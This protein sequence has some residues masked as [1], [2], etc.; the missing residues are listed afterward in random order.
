MIDKIINQMCD[1]CCDRGDFDYTKEE[2]YYQNDLEE[3][4]DFINGCGVEKLSTYMKKLIDRVDNRH[5]SSLV[6]AHRIGFENGFKAA[7][8]LIRE[9]KE[10]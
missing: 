2:R 3:I 8:K 1:E 4:R 5:N 6:K 7:A 9:L 10:V